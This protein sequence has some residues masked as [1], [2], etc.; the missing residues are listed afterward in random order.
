MSQFKEHLIQDK[1]SNE[2]YKLLAKKYPH[3]SSSIHI[4]DLVYA[5]IG[6]LSRGDIYLDVSP[7]SKAPTEIRADGWPSRH[8]KELLDSGWLTQKNSPMIKKDNLLSFRR[9]YFEMETVTNNLISRISQSNR[10]KR[11]STKVSTQN[12]QLKLNDAQLLAVNLIEHKNLILLRGGPGTGKT[13]TIAKMMLKAFLLRSNMRIG[14]AAPT[15]KAA[16]RLHESLKSSF[17]HLGEHEKNIFSSIPCLTI[18]KWLEANENGFNKNSSNQLQV[19][20]FV[21]DEMSMVD[22]HLMMGILDALPKK[23]KLVLVGDSNQLP[24]V[25]SGAIWHYLHKEHKYAKFKDSSVYLSKIYRNRGDIASLANLLINKGIDAFYKKIESLSSTSNINLVKSTKTEIPTFIIESIKSNYNKLKEISLKIF[26]LYNNKYS[27]NNNDKI[28]NELSIQVFNYM[29]EL[30]VLCPRNYGKWSVDHI[31]RVVL[32]SL[33]K[34]D[35]HWL[36]EGVPIICEEN[37]SEIGLANGDMGMTVG[38]GKLQHLLFR[39]IEKEGIQ[40]FQLIHPSRIKA[41]K[42]AFAMTIHKAQGSE[43]TNVILLWPNKLKG[44]QLKE[45]RNDDYEQKLLYTA[46]TRAREKLKLL[47]SEDLKD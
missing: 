10:H 2:L 7:N 12:Y 18:H 32:N 5:L 8:N 19:D 28:I 17:K 34:K 31:N 41:Y 26:E 13:S 36:P 35:S 14:L 42:P 6:S 15:G 37:Q 43:A 23:C 25:G 4:E 11:L 47:I 21:I 1:L 38:S 33:A 22:L 45:E 24:P 46:I 40:A 30:M 27:L 44:K 29:E 3:Q 20:L 16:R 9:W 39:V